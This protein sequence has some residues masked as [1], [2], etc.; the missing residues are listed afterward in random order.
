MAHALARGGGHPGDVGDHRLGD[1]R[2]DE[3][4]RRL[5]GAAADLAHQD[6]PLRL[7]IGLEALQA[8]DEVHALNGVTA[9]ADAGALAQAGMGGLEHRLVGQGPGAGDDADLAWLMDVA[10]HD[11]DFA[12]A[13]GDDAGAVWAYKHAGRAREGGLDLEHVQDRDALGDADDHPDAN[14]RRLED[15]VG[16]EG[17]RDIDH[18][19]VGAGLLDGIVDRVEDRAVEVLGAALAGGHAPHQ[20]GAVGDGL[21][22]ME[23]TLLASEALTNDPGVF[24]DQY[25]HVRVSSQCLAPAAATTLS[26]ASLRLAAVVMARSLAASMARPCSALVPSRRTTTGTS[27]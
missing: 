19:G 5:L 2:L 1:P 25:A 18:G 9:D 8:G 21:F 23:G 4:G 12:L 6:H 14:V 15:G 11:A 16:G 27:T 17:G 13:R 26:A 22:A 20:V 24:V 10:G 3:F 7:V